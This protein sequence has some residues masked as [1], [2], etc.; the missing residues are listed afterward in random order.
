[1]KRYGPLR[2]RAAKVAQS[3]ISIEQEADN[4]NNTV[5]MPVNFIDKD[6][7]TMSFK[8][9]TTKNFAKDKLLKNRQS[10]TNQSNHKILKRK[11]LAIQSDQN[12]LELSTPNLQNEEQQLHQRGLQIIVEN[13]ADDFQESVLSSVSSSG[14]TLTPLADLY[15]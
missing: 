4:A 14:D 5:N 8:R 7:P 11:T 1:M 13:D 2:S 15:N 6:E 10:L 9:S 12:L 3:F